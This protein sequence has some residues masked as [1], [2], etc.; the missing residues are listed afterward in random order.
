MSGR[1]A[2]PVKLRPEFA[3]FIRSAPAR[4]RADLT[5]QVADRFGVSLHRRMVERAR[6]S[7]PEARLQRMSGQQPGWSPVSRLISAQS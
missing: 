1:G 5:G 7:S 6:A 4:V 3:E 2:G